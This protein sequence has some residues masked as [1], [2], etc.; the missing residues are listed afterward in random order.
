MLSIEKC[1]EILEKHGGNYTDEEV[2]QIR[3]ILYRFAVIDYDVF[4]N[5]KYKTS[6]STDE[7]ANSSDTKID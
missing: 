4:K 5:K 1:K 2:E 3:E 7:K 6:Q